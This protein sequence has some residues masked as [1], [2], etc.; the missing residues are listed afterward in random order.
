MSKNGVIVPLR[1]VNA[2]IAALKYQARNEAAQ[3]QQPDLFDAID[4]TEWTQ[5]EELI[6][7]RKEKYHETK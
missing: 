4:T 2:A 7:L 6:K 1:L 3:S 5:A